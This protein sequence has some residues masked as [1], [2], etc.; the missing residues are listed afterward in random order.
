MN[1][2]S[3]GKKFY[4]NNNRD[5]VRRNPDENRIN[6]QIRVS[7]VRVVKDEKQLGIMSTDA[8]RKIA[9]DEGLDLVEVAP[10]ARPPVCR[11]MDYGRFKYEEKLKKKEN[12]KKQR[13]SQVQLK[14][15]RLRPGI[16][17]HDTDTKINQA[18]K[19]LEEGY[20]VQFKLQFKGQREMA[21]KDQG[22][23]VMKRVIEVLDSV[24][25]VEKSPKIEGNRITC[26]L[27]PKA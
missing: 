17:E 27:A 25:V 23:V 9:Q 22:F 13:E 11:I 2:P 6:W 16:S 7:Q 1:S 3:L 4:G 5:E 26:C 18:K 21:H 24:C 10:Q 14:E 15:L 20:R 12:A 19:F 8:A